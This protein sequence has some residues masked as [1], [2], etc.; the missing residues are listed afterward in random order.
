MRHAEIRVPGG[1]REVRHPVRLPDGD[2]RV[3]VRA[4][5]AVFERAVTISEAGTIVLPLGR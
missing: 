5:S 2:Y 3:V 1:A 4:G